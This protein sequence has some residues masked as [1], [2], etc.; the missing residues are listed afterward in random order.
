MFALRL[1][2]EAAPLPA[3]VPTTPSR[4]SPQSQ[5]FLQGKLS[6]LC[7]QMLAWVMDPL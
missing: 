5:G 6:I 7:Y 3:V 1:C 2:T 4:C